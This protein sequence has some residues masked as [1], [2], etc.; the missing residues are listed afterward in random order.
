MRFLL[1]IV[2]QR[3]VGEGGGGGGDMGCFIKAIFD[4]LSKSE[5]F[6]LY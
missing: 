2:M 5:Y 3:V 4:F 6:D 1:F